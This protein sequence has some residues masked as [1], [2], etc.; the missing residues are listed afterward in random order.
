MIVGLVADELYQLGS[1]AD[2]VQSCATVHTGVQSGP[3]Y[4]GAQ[5]CYRFEGRG[6]VMIFVVEAL[7]EARARGPLGCTPSDSEG[8]GRLR[9]LRASTYPNPS[10]QSATLRAP[11]DLSRRLTL[12]LWA[13][14]LLPV[15][16]LKCGNFFSPRAC[17]VSVTF[18]TSVLVP[19]HGSK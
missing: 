1:F 8:I 7:T 2:S 17:T 12:R 6:L 5:C 11:G 4:L 15:L 13:I 19:T 14:N 3:W 18:R 10:R 9:A 16:E